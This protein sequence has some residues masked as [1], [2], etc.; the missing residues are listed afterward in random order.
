M[1]SWTVVAESS[2]VCEGLSGLECGATEANLFLPDRE[3]KAALCIPSQISAAAWPMGGHG[4]CPLRGAW[5]HPPWLHS[6]A[7]ANLQFY[8]ILCRWCVAG[9]QG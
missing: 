4:Q 3:S 7:A 2:P 6:L 5:L 1:S 9:A 8:V